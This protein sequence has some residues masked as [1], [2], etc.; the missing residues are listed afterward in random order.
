MPAILS[1]VF[2]IGLIACFAGGGDASASA[3][4]VSAA[5]V[6]SLADGRVGAFAFES[7]TPRQIMDFVKRAPADKAMVTGMLSL[8][9]QAQ[10]PVPVIVILHGSSGINPGEWMWAKRMN[11]LG[12][13][14]FVVDSFSGR[15]IVE[16]EKDQTRLSMAVD[17]ADAYSALRLLASH[18][19]IDPRRIAVMG[20]SRGGVA[21]LYSSLEP[22]RK[23]VIDDD[24]RFA[25]HVAFY[26]S[27]G[28]HYASD[29]LDGAPVLMLL[30][31]KD[32]YTP[33]AP[34]LDYADAL[35]AKGA[36]VTVKV[37]SDAYHAFD[38]FTPLRAIPSATSA[39]LCHGEYDLDSGR[40][41]MAAG[42][43]VVSGGEA[44]IAAQACLSRGVTIG[45]DPVGREQSPALVAGFLQSAFAAE[46]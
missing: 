18:P 15:N 32:D 1:R 3:I 46:R 28:I 5:P 34:C 10:G 22:F 36:R 2:F 6:A 37:Y 17:I 16:T 44:K 24:L 7:V 12:Y 40:F 27:C 21:A 9:Q 8:P 11:E 25:A 14:S 26:P 39:R 4:T 30:G 13:A 35:K 31:G 19:A 29:H 41:T 20:F 38:R 43:G 23:G 45:G 33:A 42:N